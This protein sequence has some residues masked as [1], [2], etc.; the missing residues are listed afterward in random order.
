VNPTNQSSSALKLVRSL[1][2]V[3]LDEKS[4][5]ADLE[6]TDR[7]QSFSA[8]VLR[9]SLLTIGVF[10]FLL[11]EAILNKDSSG[12]YFEQFIS[13]KVWFVSGMV[14]LGCS[15][16]FALTHRF[17]SSDCIAY[18]I[19]YLRLKRARDEAL[20]DE[21]GASEIAKQRNVEMQEEK[22][23]LAVRL[24][25]GGR[26]LLIAAVA[27]ALGVALIATRFSLT[28]FSTPKP[29]ASRA[30]TNIVPADSSN[31]RR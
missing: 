17:V 15:A 4:Y 16:A 7:Y 12:S 23:R 28:V 13:A 25:S 6:V 20:K 18:Q 8:E 2:E 26:T 24:K 19:R 21:G 5:K 9:I 27:L 3:A 11:K 30:T 14:A 31:L 29:P 22:E 10:G 1:S